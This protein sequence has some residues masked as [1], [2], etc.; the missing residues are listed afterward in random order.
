M[1]AAF[2]QAG[3]AQTA[4]APAAKPADAKDQILATVNGVPIYVSEVTSEIENLPEQYRGMPAD[5]LMPLML[6]T[7]LTPP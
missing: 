4:P 7:V 5:R 3:L 2:P 6:A 1:F